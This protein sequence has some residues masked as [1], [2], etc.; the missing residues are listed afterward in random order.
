M[1]TSASPSPE[2]GAPDPNTPQGSASP[3]SWSAPTAARLAAG[4]AAPDPLTWVLTGD[5]ITQG[6]YH[7]YGARSWAEHLHERVRSELG[8]A[9]DIIINTGVAGW[10]APQVLDDFQHLVARFAPDVVSIALGMNDSLAGDQGLPFFI[11]GLDELTVRSF[12][13]DAVVVL[14]T[15]NAIA[16]G[17]WNTPESVAAYAAA[18]RDIAAQR[19]ALLVDHH[20]DWIA[21]YGQGDPRPW[22]DEPVH[23]NAAGHRAMADS[24]FRALGLD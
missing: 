19:G 6:V 1:A 11:R 10:T 17:A 9:R 22:L 20:A 16:Q 7:T 23:P 21:R 12:A 8:R 4:L 15:P 3:A 24:T 5:S 14:H 2:P 18:V 13:L